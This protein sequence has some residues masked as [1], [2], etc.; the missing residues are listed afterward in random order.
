[1]S[2]S[3]MKSIIG[4]P[5]LSN[6]FRTSKIGLQSS[7]IPENSPAEKNKGKSY[8]KILEGKTTAIESI[9]NTSS[10]LDNYKRGNLFSRE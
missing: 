1:M 3:F 9:T 4:S 5:K 10:I 7:R 8:T 6:T 2:N